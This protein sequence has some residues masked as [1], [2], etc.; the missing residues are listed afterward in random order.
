MGPTA[1][2]STKVGMHYQSFSKKELYTS[3]YTPMKLINFIVS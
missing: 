1:S 3:C 2:E